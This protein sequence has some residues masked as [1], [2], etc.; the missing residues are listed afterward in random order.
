MPLDTLTARQRSPAWLR[1]FPAL[2]P[3]SDLSPKPVF[4]A[5]KET[6]LK[7]SAFSEG[8]HG[9]ICILILDSNCFHN[10]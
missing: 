5:F 9:G 4:V 1:R 3:T 7:N 2:L 6:T 8:I 10:R